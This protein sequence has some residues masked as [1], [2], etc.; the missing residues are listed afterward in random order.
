MKVKINPDLIVIGGGLA[1]SEAAWQAAS[2]GIRVRLLEM[3]PE[4]MT[5]AHRTSNLAELVCSNSLGSNLPDRASGIL[6]QELRSLNSLLLKCDDEAVVPAGGALAVDREA[7][8]QKATEQIES[9]PLI[10]VIRQEITEIPN[11]PAI[12]ASGP[13]TSPQLSKA[14]QN[15]TGSEQIFFYDALAPVVNQVS[16]NMEIVFQGSRYGK[17]NGE[18]C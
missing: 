2:R 5:G 3:R 9:H 17:I 10:E 16:I 7:F 6:K 15:L 8:S 18:S 13:L 1:G 11:P 4:V 12:I 14:I